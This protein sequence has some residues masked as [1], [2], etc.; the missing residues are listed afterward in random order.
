MKR[1]EIYFNREVYFLTAETSQYVK[2]GIVQSERKSEDRKKNT[3]Q[4][5]PARLLLKQELK[6]RLMP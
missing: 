2:I 3:K 4:V 1:G 5:I 6:T